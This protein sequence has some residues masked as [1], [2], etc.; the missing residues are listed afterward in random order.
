MRYKDVFLD[1]LRSEIAGM[2]RKSRIFSLLKEELGAIGYWKN[3]ARG[4]PAKGYAKSSHK[5]GV[6]GTF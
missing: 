3:K 5:I 2:T 1:K 4:N 6:N